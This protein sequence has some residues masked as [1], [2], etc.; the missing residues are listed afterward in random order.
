[1]SISAPSALERHQEEIDRARADGAA[2]GQRDPGLAHARQER[3][4][5]PEARPH[6]RHEVVGRGGVDDVGGG[7]SVD[8]S[9]RFPSLSPMRLPAT[10]CRRRDWRMRS[11]CL[12]SARRGHIGQRQ[13]LVGTGATR[14]SAA[15]RVLGAGNRDHAIEALA[16]GDADTVHRARPAGR[17]AEAPAGKNGDQDRG[18]SAWAGGGVSSAAVSEAR[19]ALACALRRFRFSRRAAARRALLSSSAS[20]WRLK[21]SA[22]RNA[23]NLAAADVG[24]WL[25]AEPAPDKTRAAHNIPC[26]VD[27]GT[28]AASPVSG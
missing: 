18:G 9:G 3:P 2:A 7:G 4:D 5:H 23:R 14:S 1:M 26:T 22:R 15:G 17:P 21:A 24:S 12:T 16:A 25:A 6:L 19:R 11:S 28:T 27:C 10:E 20:V 8:A 13:R